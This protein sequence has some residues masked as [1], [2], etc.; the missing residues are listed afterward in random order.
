M[1]V[2][3]LRPEGTSLPSVDALMEAGHWKRAREI[4]LARLKANPHDAQAHS[5]LSKIASSFGDLE[6]AV[7]EAEKAVELDGR[8]PAFHSQLAEACALTAD[9]SSVIKGL[10]YVR[11]MKRE[12]E[13]A[14]ALDPNHIDTMLV[15]MMFSWKAPALAGG[16]KQKAKR[17]A[18]RILSISPSW[19]YLA[20]ARL[21]QF[22]GNDP[23]TE[24]VLKKAV[25]ADPSFYRA[26]ISLA[27]FYCGEQNCPAPTTAARLAQEAL[28]LDPAAEGG[29]EVLA[30]ALAAQKQLS[31]LD[32][33]LERAEHL[34]PDDLA[35][36]YAAAKRLL[37]SGQDFD[38][39]ERYLQ[40]YLQQPAEGRQPTQA[41]ARRLLTEL[42][43]RSGRHS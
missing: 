3:V 24:V 1:C 32:A 36:Y 27:T 16:D 34:V 38:R 8:N 15:E 41:E 12:I 18:D 33:V 2:C 20:Q 35:P 42:Y 31:D 11:R 40:H 7:R 22:Q 39:A 4:S 13:A 25:Q 37:D 29:Y 14:L 6:T 21:Y 23:A 9:R 30:R 10:V 17:V 28:A 26:R 19:G 43:R 5:W